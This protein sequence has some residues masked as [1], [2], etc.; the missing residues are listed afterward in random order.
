MNETDGKNLRHTNLLTSVEDA[1]A[2]N[3]MPL[4]DF[5]KG[6]VAGIYAWIDPTGRFLYIGQSEKISARLSNH[7]FNNK[8]NPDYG[9]VAIVIIL[10]D[11]YRDYAEHMLIHLMQPVFNQRRGGG[12]FKGENA[13]Y[14]EYKKYLA[15]LIHIPFRG[16][17]NIK[18]GQA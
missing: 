3:W 2:L 5:K 6:K 15:S 1:A 16:R 18:D 13:Y 9:M 11:D 14:E 8:I 7:L 10:D 12:R 17:M 4:S